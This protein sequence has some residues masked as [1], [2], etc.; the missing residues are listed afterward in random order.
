MR[1]RFGVA[2]A[3]ALIALLAGCAGQ[4][5]F[6][7]SDPAYK[8]LHAGRYSEARAPLAAELA[9]DPDNPYLQFDMASDYQNL[10]HMEL[11][12]PLYRKVIANAKDIVPAVASDPT[13]AGMTLSD[14][15]CTNLRRG[16]HDNF[17]C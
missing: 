6:N 9:R 8:L 4:P 5:N 17:T 11:A 3:G 1:I 2:P 7:P 13:E 16:L 12:A 15:A 10:G 14:M